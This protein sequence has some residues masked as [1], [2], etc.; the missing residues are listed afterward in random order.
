MEAVMSV[1]LKPRRPF[2]R[3]ITGLELMDGKA[4]GLDGT[5]I[6]LCKGGD[7]LWKPPA[8]LEDG[9][10]DAISDQ[11][12]WIFIKGDRKREEV[13]PFS[14]RYRINHWRNDHN[15]ETE[16]FD[17]DVLEAKPDHC[18]K[19]ALADDDQAWRHLLAVLERKHKS[20]G[21]RDE[22]IPYEALYSI[23]DI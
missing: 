14:F 5:W 18:C 16:E 22:R 15:S 1:I 20:I 7:G 23:D 17:N 4:T 10:Y 13:S 19:R 12:L 2:L 21:T 6:D 8:D 9:I 3:R 11:R